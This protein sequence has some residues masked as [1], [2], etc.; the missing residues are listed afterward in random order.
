[1]RG[2]CW[3]VLGFDVGVIVIVQGIAKLVKG[4]WRS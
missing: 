3:I 2:V 1:M 4:V